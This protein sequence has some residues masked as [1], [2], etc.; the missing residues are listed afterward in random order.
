MSKEQSAIDVL[1]AHRQVETL[2]AARPAWWLIFTRELTDLWVGGKAL[3]LILIYG[4]LLGIASF[5]TANNSELDLIPPKEMVFFTLQIAFGVGV[6]M[7]LVI[8][9]DILSGERERSTLEGLLLTPASRRQ[10]I[11]G[12]FL[13]CISPW[14]LVFIITIPFLY[15]F[16]QD[17]PIFGQ[18]LFLGSLMG[19]I[20]VVGFAGL[21]ILIS[22]WSNSNKV[23]YFLSLTLYILF[24]VPTQWPGQAQK[25]VVGKFVQRVK[26][27]EATNEFLEKIL[28]NN[29][30]LHEYQSWLRGPVVFTAIILILLFLYAGPRLRLYAS[31]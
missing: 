17:D 16:A 25:G 2:G 23:S 8:G 4:F 26:P 15:L 19:S 28:V 11:L 9:A 1:D 27:M 18:T 24:L 22:Y 3:Y 6:F 29:R 10:I 12:K 14:P 21:G 20:L 31:R 5:V 30:T 7:S 13:A